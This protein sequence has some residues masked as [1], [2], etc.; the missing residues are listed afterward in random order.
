M[1]DLPPPNT[2]R[3]VARRKAAVVAAVCAGRRKSCAVTSSPR[4]SSSRGS[5]RLR[6]MVCP[7]CGQPASSN[8]VDR[9]G[10]GH[11]ER[12]AEPESFPQTRYGALW[13]RSAPSAAHGSPRRQPL[14]KRRLRSSCLGDLDR[15]NFQALHSR[16]CRTPRPP[17][18]DVL[19]G[20]RK[21]SAACCTARRGAR[22]ANALSSHARLTADSR[23]RIK[24]RNPSQ[25]KRDERIR[26]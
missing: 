20:E 11:P 2:G 10:H 4:R 19:A 18:N 6:A 12:S 8:I 15:R 22:G 7:V 9:G 1:D 3:W 13:A 24:L 25:G 14:F 23:G 17:V 5:A 16:R 26:H 21:R